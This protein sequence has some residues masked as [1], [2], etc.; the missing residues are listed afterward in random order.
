MDPGRHRVPALLRNGALFLFGEGPKRAGPGDARGDARVADPYLDG[1]LLLGRVGFHLGRPPAGRLLARG[2]FPV[3]GEA[4]RHEPTRL[5]ARDR[6]HAALVRRNRAAVRLVHPLLQAWGSGEFHPDD[7]D[8]LLRK[9]DLSG[10][11]P[12]GQRSGSLGMAADDLVPQGRPG[13]APPGRRSFRAAGGDPAA[14]RPDR[15]ARSPGAF[16]VPDRHP[17]GEAGGVAGSVL[18]VSPPAAARIA[19]NSIGA[20]EVAMR[21]VAMAAAA[22]MALIG[23]AGVRADDSNARTIQIAMGLAQRG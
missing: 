16:R 12:A 22:G 9:R 13:V 20:G 14:R 3:R 19:V 15:R 2:G 11:G 8:D 4:P 23:W 10:E 21:Y 17:E 5:D 7:G 18:K 6:P 1:D